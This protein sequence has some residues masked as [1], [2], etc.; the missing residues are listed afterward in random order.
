MKTRKEV[1]KELVKLCRG[2]FSKAGYDGKRAKAYKDFSVE[3]YVYGNPALRNDVLRFLRG[4][5]Q[6]AESDCN[7]VWNSDGHRLYLTIC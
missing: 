4:F 6:F 3:L 5:P 2:W 7:F 1:Q